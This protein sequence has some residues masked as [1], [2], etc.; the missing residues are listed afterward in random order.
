MVTV[1]VFFGAVEF[2]VGFEVFDF[3]VTELVVLVVKC[4]VARTVHAAITLV[5]ISIDCNTQQISQTSFM[6]YDITI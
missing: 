5:P 4:V 3:E 2:R 1:V 6:L